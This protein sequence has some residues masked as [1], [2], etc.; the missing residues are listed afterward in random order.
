MIRSNYWSKE[1]EL[2]ESVMPYRVQHILI[3]ASLYDS[4]IFE[5]DGFLAEQ[6]AEDF[7]LLNLSTQPEL[8]HASSVDSAINRLQYEQI[9]IVIIHLASMRGIALEL[10]N[11]IKNEYPDMPVIFL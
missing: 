6:V 4:F 5:V 9:D 8:F 1:L 7:Y 10:L 3:I 2:I 11:V